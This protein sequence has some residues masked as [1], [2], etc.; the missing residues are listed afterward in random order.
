MKIDQLG[1]GFREFQFVLFFCLVG[2]VFIKQHCEIL[3]TSYEFVT[4]YT[5]QYHFDF[6]NVML[7]IMLC[8]LLVTFSFCSYEYTIVCI[9]WE[10]VGGMSESKCFKG[11]NNNIKP[12]SQNGRAY[13]VV[14]FF[15]YLSFPL[16][17]PFVNVSFILFTEINIKCCVGMSWYWCRVLCW[18]DEILNP[19]SFLA[20][21]RGLIKSYNLWLSVWLF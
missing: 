7:Q 11:I 12:R 5:I 3:R 8:F 10:R 18:N 13:F 16:K 9:L 2:A 19:T 1:L 14:L 4:F 17:F 6:G 21:F 15:I 20:S